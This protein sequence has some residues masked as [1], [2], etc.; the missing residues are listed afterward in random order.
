MSPPLPFPPSLH[1]SLSLLL[2]PSLPP[3]PS[4]SLPP[5][6]SPSP[7]HPHPH[8]LLH[9]HKGSSKS[10]E[11]DG[12]DVRQYLI[13]ALILLYECIRYPPL[14]RRGGGRGANSP[15]HNLRNCRLCK[16][17]LWQP[18]RTIKRLKMI[19]SYNACQSFRITAKAFK[20]L[21]II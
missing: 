19:R 21:G 10:P 5:S 20:L 15:P 6:P 7:S 2:H 13:D 1:P 8:T 12:H 16:H 17:Q 11:N 3:S 4:P 14:L 18:I 9:P